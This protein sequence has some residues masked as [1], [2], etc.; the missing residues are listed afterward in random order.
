[1]LWLQTGPAGSSNLC[2][3]LGALLKV[4]KAQTLVCNNVEDVLSLYHVAWL[5]MLLGA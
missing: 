5:N 4:R 3:V 1:M 2:L